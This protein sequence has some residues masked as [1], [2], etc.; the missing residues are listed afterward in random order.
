MSGGVDS[1][2]AA[3]LLQQQGHDVVGITMQHLDR[4]RLSVAGASKEP[5]QAV[6]DA[7]AVCRQLG[8]AHHVVDLREPFQRQVIDHFVDE[9][10]AGRT[11]NPCVA[12]NVTIKWG[13]LL[14]ACRQTGADYIATGHYSRVTFDQQ[15]GRYLLRKAAYQAKDQSYALW[16]LTQEQLART[17]F[18]LAGMTKEQVRQAAAEIGLTVAHKGESQDVC[19]ILDDDYQRFIIDELRQRGCFVASGDFVDQFDRV[20]G[21]HHGYPF[22]TIGQRKGLGL[23]MGRAVF[24]TEIDVKG[25]RI[26]IGDKEDLLATGLVAEQAN[27]IA[28]ADPPVGALVEARI[29]YKDPGYPAVIDS[30]EG[31]QVRVLF[32]EPRPAITPGQSAVFYQEEVL[33]GGGIITQAI[34]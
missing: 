6:R 34:K 21:R 19:F 27:W 31:G 7:A 1:S 28:Y 3:A 9:Y 17:M 30:A 14:D 15:R 4:Q 11:P 25:N 2:V 13:A 16:R 22:Y 8:I 23:S 32:Q 10:L 5:E 33:I 26:R 24:V 29:R 20:L 12:C 18:P